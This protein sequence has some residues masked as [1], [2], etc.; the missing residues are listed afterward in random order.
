M[1]PYFRTEVAIND[2]FDSL[3]K[4]R[5]QRFC[6]SGIFVSKF[7]QSRCDWLLNSAEGAFLFPVPVRRLAEMFT[8]FLAT[9]I[10]VTS[11]NL[12][13]TTLTNCHAHAWDFRGE[14]VLGLLITVSNHLLR[15]IS[16]L[17]RLLGCRA[18]AQHDVELHTWYPKFDKLPQSKS[19]AGKTFAKPNLI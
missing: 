6:W 19:L 15:K 12:L 2:K 13:Q 16:T 3:K 17:R 8:V 4:S 18:G 7:Y 1:S 9:P 11:A 14:L 5:F 10:R